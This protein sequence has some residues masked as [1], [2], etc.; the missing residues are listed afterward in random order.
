MFT[1]IVVRADGTL[2][3]PPN[4]FHSLEDAIAAATKRLHPIPRPSL[5]GETRTCVVM[6]DDSEYMRL[7]RTF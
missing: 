4:V 2:Y 3:A 1:I 6:E 5:A 7:S